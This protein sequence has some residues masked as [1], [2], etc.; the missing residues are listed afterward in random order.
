VKTKF[1]YLSYFFVFLT[2]G[3]FIYFL[4]MFTTLYKIISNSEK[5]IAAVIIGMAC[6]LIGLCYGIYVLTLVLYK[7]KYSIKIDNSYL[8]IFDPIKNRQTEFRFDFIENIQLENHFRGTV[9]TT[10][11]ITTK[12]GE[13]YKILNF[14]IWN[15]KD[16][17]IAL[18]KLKQKKT[19]IKISIVTNSITIDYF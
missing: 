9:F 5:N 7:F 19:G 3:G 4:A 16:L 13:K 2:L 1:N 11:I 6:V 17:R 15:F 10:L 18:N 8:T 14:F 12:S